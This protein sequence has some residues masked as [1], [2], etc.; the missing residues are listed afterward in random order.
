MLVD[1]FALEN[2]L[3]SQFSIF[4]AARI[5]VS[6]TNSRLWLLYWHNPNEQTYK[7]TQ[8][9]AVSDACSYKPMAF[10][11]VVFF[12]LIRER[13]QQTDNSEKQRQ[14]ERQRKK[15]WKSDRPRNSERKSEKKSPHKCKGRKKCNPPPTP[16]SHLFG[17]VLYIQLASNGLTWQLWDL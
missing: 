9:P 3:Y 8:T 14:S 11:V 7:A 13:D 2:I 12:S 16:L 5:L 4:I 17:T 1:F 15:E 10:V 6:A